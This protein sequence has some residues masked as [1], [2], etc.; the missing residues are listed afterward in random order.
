MKIHDGILQV[1]SKELLEKVAHFGS[2]DVKDMKKNIEKLT[3][4]FQ[5]KISKIHECLT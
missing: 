1:L 4:E 2:S 3:A 5:N